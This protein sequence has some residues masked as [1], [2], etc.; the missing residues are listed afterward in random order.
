[1]GKVGTNAV[2]PTPFGVVAVTTKDYRRITTGKP[3]VR[4]NLTNPGVF[5]TDG[6]YTAQIVT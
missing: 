3:V 6:P 5:D 1:M 2:T 4:K